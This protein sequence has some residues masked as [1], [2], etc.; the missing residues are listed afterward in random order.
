M[1]YLFDDKLKVLCNM[2]LAY[3]HWYERNERRKQEEA[4]GQ[5]MQE[6]QDKIKKRPGLTEF[7]KKLITLNDDQLNEFMQMIKK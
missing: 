5:L 2:P 6:I 1:E 4:Q 7:F 3:W